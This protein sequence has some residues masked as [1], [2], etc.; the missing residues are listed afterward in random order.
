MNYDQDNFNT[1]NSNMQGNPDNMNGLSTAAQV[2]GI[3]SMVLGILTLISCCLGYLS[4]P[5]GALGILFA[6]LSRRKGEKLSSISKTG[7]TLSIV[8]LIIG[9][10]M[11]MLSLYSVITNPNFWESMK[12][13]YEQY[14][15]MYEEIYGIELEDYN[16]LT[17]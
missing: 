10:M 2:C 5:I 16:S 8:G 11:F 14:E 3:I 7:L 4:I 1:Q 6:V 9:I 15:E 13:T 17:L 12:E